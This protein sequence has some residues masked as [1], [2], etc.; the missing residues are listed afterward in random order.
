MGKNTRSFSSCT[1]FVL[2]L[3]V[4]ASSLLVAAPSVSAAPLANGTSEC[5]PWGDAYVEVGLITYLGGGTE[6]ATVEYSASA[7]TFVL[8]FS[9]VGATGEEEVPLPGNLFIEPNF[10]SDSSCSQ[11]IS[12]TVSACLTPVKSGSDLFP[13]GP[14]PIGFTTYL[15]NSISGGDPSVQLRWQNDADNASFYPDY[16]YSWYENIP[17]QQN[18]EGSLVLTLLSSEQITDLG[19]NAVDATVA[20]VLCDASAAGGGGTEGGT[21]PGI[22]WDYYTERAR[23]SEGASL[24]NTR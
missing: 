18:L 21:R 12:L 13:D 8:Q 19:D 6:W 16:N 23:A 1:R 11:P 9:S 10:Y 4:L 17:V 2:G 7:T 20:G 5:V 22:D 3:G 24:P 14:Y 15:N